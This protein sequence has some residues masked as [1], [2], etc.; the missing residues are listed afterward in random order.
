LT[1][2]DYGFHPKGIFAGNFKHVFN[3]D[4][5]SNKASLLLTSKVHGEDLSFNKLSSI[6]RID[7]HYKF[8]VIDEESL[9]IYDF[10][11]PSEPISRVNHY[12]H[13]IDSFAD[14]IL[15]KSHINNDLALSDFE[16][17][18]INNMSMLI[19]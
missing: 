1:Y 13:E 8:T 16:H 10:R 17:L 7:D 5:R 4:L 2:F 14:I 12:M 11:E 6:K 3:I 9:L 18:D 15:P 19:H